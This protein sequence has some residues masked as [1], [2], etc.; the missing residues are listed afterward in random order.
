MEHYELDAYCREFQGKVLSCLPSQRK[1]GDFFEIELDATA[2]YPEGGGQ[3][4][5]LGFLDAVAILHVQKKDGKVIH[6]VKEEIPLG[7]LVTGVIDWER[8][9]DLMQQ[10][11]GEH[12]VS[13]FAHK[14]FGCDNVGFHMG[15]ELVTIDFN[16]EL[17]LEQV[18]Q[19]E[20]KTN[21]YIL[22]N[23]PVQISYP[24]PTDL[25]TL[26]FR[27]KK[28]LSGDV[29]ILTF[30]NADVCACCGTHVKSAGEIRLVKIVSCQKFREGVRLELLCGERAIAY[31]EKN[32]QENKKISHLLSAKQEETAKAVEKLQLEKEKL[33]L[34]LKKME[35]NQVNHL[36]TEHQ[37]K[38]LLFV[39]DISIDSLR[40]LGTALAEKLPHLEICACFLLEEKLFRYAITSQEGDVRSL[41][42]ELNQ[43]FSGRGGGKEHLAQGSLTAKKE[44]LESFF[45]NYPK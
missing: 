31:F 33:S 14:M 7:T 30:P 24:S 9:F 12:I 19:I 10:H 36:V 44:E 2:F 6:I 32:L 38:K 16:V 25:E 26:D 13:G 1:D 34:A 35:Q 27:S 11:S 4:C 17:S 20:K 29:R 37:G 42:K 43:T 21:E 22:E 39:E 15:K 3:P 28:E 40:I 18:E 8:R 5:D 45:E 23:H 41:V